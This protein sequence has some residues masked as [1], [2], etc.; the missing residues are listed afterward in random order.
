[1]PDS[2]VLTST[3]GGDLRHAA[4]D[5][6]LTSF[7]DIGVFFGVLLVGFAYVWKRGDL[8]WVRTVTRGLFFS[9]R[10]TGMVGCKSY[11]G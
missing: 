7:A 8:D 10:T 11:K 1:M 5:L 3:D 6:A 4:R 2:A 9:V